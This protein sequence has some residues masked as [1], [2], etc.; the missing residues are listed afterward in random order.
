MQFLFCVCMLIVISMLD[1]AG[2]SALVDICVGGFSA[3]FVCLHDLFTMQ[4]VYNWLSERL[5]Y[6]GIHIISISSKLRLISFPILMSK[7]Y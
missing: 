4:F 7:L 3:N 1:R 6:P 2:A 5:F